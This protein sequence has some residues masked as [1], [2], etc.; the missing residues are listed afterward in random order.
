M[1]GPFSTVCA[2]HVAMPIF[3]EAAIDISSFPCFVRM[4]VIE[5]QV[6]CYEVSGAGGE[7]NELCLGNTA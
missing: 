6:C 4:N 1:I 5:L 7:G 3:V 2:L